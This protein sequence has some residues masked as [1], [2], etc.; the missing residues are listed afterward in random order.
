M[1]EEITTEEFLADLDEARK[2]VEALQQ[3]NVSK[4]EALHKFGRAIP[5]Q[6][7]ANIK[8]DLFVEMFLDEGSKLLYLYN[9]EVKL[10]PFLDEALAQARQEQLT[11]ATPAQPQLYIPR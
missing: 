8:T 7:L 2:R 6:L 10:R 1:P 4:V 3:S 5:L 11:K 9:L